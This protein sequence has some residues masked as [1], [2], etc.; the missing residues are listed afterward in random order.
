MDMVNKTDL[1]R[2]IRTAGHTYETL[3][4]E[5]G[6]TAQGIAEIVAGRTRSAT[7]RYA[8]AAAL[9]KTVDELWPEEQQAA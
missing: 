9:G 3:G 4:Q 2:I 5:I 8:V 6:I 1:K 7:S